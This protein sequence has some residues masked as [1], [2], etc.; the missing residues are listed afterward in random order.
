MSYSLQDLI[1]ELDAIIPEVEQEII[2][3]KAC[4]AGNGSVE[5]L[6]YIKTELEQI[7]KQAQANA[8]PP[9]DKRYTAY[10]RY[11]IDEWDMNS[12]MGKR[13]CNLADKYRRKV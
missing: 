2:S 10:S 13:L 5:Q 9:K 12:S 11:V 6:E 3:R 7:R 8:L 4:I 1:N